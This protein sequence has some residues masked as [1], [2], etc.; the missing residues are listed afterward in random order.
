MLMGI[1][2]LFR[3]DE[4]IIDVVH[5][6]ENGKYMNVINAD[7]THI[8]QDLLFGSNCTR[9]RQGNLLFN[10]ALIFAREYESPYMN[11]PCGHGGTA[12]VGA[13][14]LGPPNNPP[15]TIPKSDASAFSSSQSKGDVSEAEGSEENQCKP[16]VVAPK[17]VG[18]AKAGALNG[19]G[20]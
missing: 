3:D 17:S 8:T 6:F 5:T 2:S 20:N 1:E 14:V 10:I 11:P 18:E 4:V 13:V 7:E 12:R 15:T 19:G 16:E 9:L